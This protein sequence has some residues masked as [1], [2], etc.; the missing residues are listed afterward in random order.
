MSSAMPCYMRLLQ[1]NY[2]ASMSRWT[3][4][5]V[6]IR[7]WIG[8]GGSRWYGG[9]PCPPKPH[10]RGS[11]HGA[12]APEIRCSGGGRASTTGAAGRMP[13]VARR[14]RR[15][16]GRR[17]ERGCSSPSPP[18]VLF[19]LPIIPILVLPTTVLAVQLPVSSSP[20][21]EQ[22]KL[23]SASLQPPLEEHRLGSALE[24]GLVA[25]G[26]PPWWARVGSMGAI[27]RVRRTG[28]E[29]GD[30]GRGRGVLGQR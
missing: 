5:S 17:C 10:C 24:N 30:M 6:W 15:S 12:A 8:T 11:Q 29:E 28:G 20:K 16:L 22:Y 25:W 14:R 23:R 19:L 9:I 7:W 21:R 27:T 4:G 3:G 26:R 2:N 1:I 13:M 18:F